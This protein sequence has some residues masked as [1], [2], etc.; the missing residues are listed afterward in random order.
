ML[1]WSDLRDVSVSNMF[2]WYSQWRSL[3]CFTGSGYRNTD[4]PCLA[5]SHEFF[6]VCWN[7]QIFSSFFS[8][9]G[10]FIELDDGKIS[11]KAL[12]LMVKTMVSCRFSLKPIHWLVTWS[13]SIVRSVSVTSWRP[14][15]ARPSTRPPRCGAARRNWR[16]QTARRRCWEMWSSVGRKRHGYEGRRERGIC[17][18]GICWVILNSTW[19][20]FYVKI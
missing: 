12:Y 13:V 18:L 14:S 7:P 6:H 20:R 3:C 19:K 4:F 11:R 10:W 9:F 1:G 15:G 2:K 16:R 8:I 5:N 17:W